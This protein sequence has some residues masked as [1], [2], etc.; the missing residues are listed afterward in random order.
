MIT[1]TLT[2]AAFRKEARR[3]PH[4]RGLWRRNCSSTERGGSWG[5]DWDWDWIWHDEPAATPADAPSS[6]GATIQTLSAPQFL[7]LVQPVRMVHCRSDDDGTGSLDPDTDAWDEE[8]VIVGDELTVPTA[9]KAIR[10]EGFQ[11]WQIHIVYSCTWQ[12]P[13]LY[14]NAR[15]VDGRPA[16]WQEVRPLLP[17]SLDAVEAGAAVWPSV[18][19]EAHP[20]TG[21]PCFMLH[22][23]HT[24]A[25]M[26]GMM[27]NTG[28]AAGSDDR[29]E[30]HEREEKDSTRTS[31]YLLCWF[32]MVA[33]AVGLSVPPPF[34]QEYA[35]Y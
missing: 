10:R 5:W 27:K 28:S 9:P 29:C 1:G 2:E 25:R 20:G 4:L 23:C 22:P 11:E 16:T 31:R 6:G 18:T 34:F 33:P 14:F 30:S 24:A 19:Q 3:W 17:V 21:T 8:G 13:V 12:V 26:K 7:T 15:H 32:S 35:R